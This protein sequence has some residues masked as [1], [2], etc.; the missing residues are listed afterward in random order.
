MK[1]L[2]IIEESDGTEL[3]VSYAEEVDSSF[4]ATAHVEIGVADDYVYIDNLSDLEY[5]IE[6]LR[7]YRDKMIKHLAKNDEPNQ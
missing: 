2:V 1:K 4:K 6:E 7:E 5:L 3:H